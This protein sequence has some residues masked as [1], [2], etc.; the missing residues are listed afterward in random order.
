MWVAVFV[1]GI[2]LVLGFGRLIGLSGGSGILGGL[3][4]V[5]L[6]TVGAGGLW[7]IGAALLAGGLSLAFWGSA[8]K[9]YGIDS[10]RIAKMPLFGLFT[11]V[12]PAILV[13]FG[14]V[15]LL[16]R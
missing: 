1:V 15:L 2:L 16:L 5:I 9:S 4:G 7:G 6:S 11:G 3:I 12:V 13:I 10:P 8:V 14:L